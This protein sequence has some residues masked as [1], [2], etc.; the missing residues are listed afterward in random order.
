MSTQINLLPWREEVKKVRK[1]Q[2]IAMVAVAAVIGVGVV[3]GGNMYLQGMIDHQEHRNQL[4][5]TEI[6]RLD[7][8]IQRIQELERTRDQL[9][10]RMNVIQELQTGR[11]Q[12]VHMFEELV[13]TLPDGVFLKTVTQQGGNITITGVGQ[14]NA[15]VSTYMERL[16]GSAW[17]TDPNLDVIEVR[18][19]EGIRV[20]NFTLRVRQ[21]NPGADNGEG[22]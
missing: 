20:S 8:R 21:T 4:L 2:F 6:T 22:A 16:D 9:E 1:N 18:D 13:S 10:A 19:R 3:F 15:R 5:R 11:P 12:V 7:T 14:S 17:F